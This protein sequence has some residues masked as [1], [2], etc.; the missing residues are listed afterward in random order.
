MAREGHNGSLEMK[1]TQKGKHFLFR[2]IRTIIAVITSE[3][4]MR[5]VLSG[6]LAFI[7]CLISSLQ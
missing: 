7:S 6:A 3:A 5:D 4:H 1:D 2:I